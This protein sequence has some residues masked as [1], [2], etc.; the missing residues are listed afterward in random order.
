MVMVIRNQYWLSVWNRKQTAVC[1]IKVWCST[2]PPTL[3]L[4]IRRLCCTITSHSLYD[5][6]KQLSKLGCFFVV[7]SLE[8]YQML[9]LDYYSNDRN[10]C[11]RTVSKRHNTPSFPNPN[12]NLPIIFIQ[13]LNLV[14]LHGK[15]LWLFYFLLPWQVIH[16]T[17][18]G[19]DCTNIS[20]MLVGGGNVNSLWRQKTRLLFLTNFQM[21]INMYNVKGIF[22]H[23][24]FCFFDIILYKMGM[25]VNIWYLYVWWV[26]L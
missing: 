4:Y 17:N 14:W 5:A 24:C 6:D 12:P 11:L 26:K 10:C 25:D 18:M 13:S 8:C 16:G 1:Q 3:T 9:F 19:N 20:L 22:S 2:H 23:L 21:S 15:W 7:L